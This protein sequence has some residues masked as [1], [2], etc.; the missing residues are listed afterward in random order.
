MTYIG[1]EIKRARQALGMTS[2]EIAERVTLTPQYIRLIECGGAVPSM[3]TVLSICNLFP[4]ADSA[5]W[6]WLLLA[7][8]WGPAAVEVMR[9]QAARQ[10]GSSSD[11][12]EVGD[13]QAL[14]PVAAR[15]E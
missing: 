9:A 12:G 11:A 4:D 14:L 5:T 6:L 3:P 15:D 10:Q 2:R 1:S 7:D 13:G 8:M